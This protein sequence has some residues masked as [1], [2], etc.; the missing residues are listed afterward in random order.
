VA[1]PTHVRSASSSNGIPAIQCSGTNRLAIVTVAN[2]SS[3]TPTGVTFGGVAM[4]R[5]TAGLPADTATFRDTAHRWTLWY[6]IAPPVVAS[7]AVVVSY[8]VAPSFRDII[9]NLF[10]GVKQSSPIVNLA[11]DVNLTGGETTSNTVSPTSVV[12]QLIVACLA[13]DDFA[14]SPLSGGSQT[15]LQDRSWNHVDSKAAAAGST[16]VS[17]TW[18]GAQESSIYAFALEPF[19]GITSS[20]A[21]ATQ[22]HVIASAGSERLPSAGASAI[23]QHAVASAGSVAAQVTS[24]GALALK[25]HAIAAAGSEQLT[26]AAALA[27]QQQAIAAAGSSAAPVTSAGTLAVQQHAIVAAGA[28]Q[29]PSAGALA[30]Q[31]HAIAALGLTGANPVGA[32][33]LAL[34]QHTIAAA[35]V[36]DPT[37]SS[38]AAMAL[39]QHVVASAGA[40]TLP[41]AG[42]PAVKQHA[43]AASTFANN[44]VAASGLLALQQHAVSAG[45][46]VANVVTGAGTVAISAFALASFVV[47]GSQQREREGPLHL[48]G[49]R[50]AMRSGGGASRRIGTSTGGG[51][52]TT[53]PSRGRR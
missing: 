2:D 28:E 24:T 10:E 15:R 11:Y 35:G 18:I 42:A 9:V 7:A 23:K 20:G 32:G 3:Q 6:L 33:A 39:R 34:K 46:S 51:R 21:L 26:G 47:V 30:T 29:F 1:A 22:Q 13:M 14:Q 53:K 41:S 36:A 50:P 43:I 49:P 25:Q 27:V 40:E 37:V 12:D 52:S 5:F 19:D 4:T 17:F 44:P 45:S 31:Q 16:T 8:A 38:T 48:S